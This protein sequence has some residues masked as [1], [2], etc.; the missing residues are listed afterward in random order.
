ML[1]FYLVGTVQNQEKLS[2]QK[3]SEIL[4]MEN[5]LLLVELVM[6]ITRE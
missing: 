6:E 4:K 3:L 5:H 1:K 2:T